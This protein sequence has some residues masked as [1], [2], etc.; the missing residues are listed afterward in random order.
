VPAEDV[1]QAE[2]YRAALTGQFSQ[3]SDVQF[4]VRNEKGISVVDIKSIPM[5]EMGTLILAL[6]NHV[7]GNGPRREE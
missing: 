6:M 1:A 5:A 4:K 3:G 2:K 7:P